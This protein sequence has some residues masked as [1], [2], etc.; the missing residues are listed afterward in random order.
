MSFSI[1]GL[2]T[3]VPPNC[4]SQEDA[5]E[6]S[7]ELICEDTR[8]QRLLRV[9]FRQSGVENRHTVIP[10]QTGYTCKRDEGQLGSGRGPT[11]ADT[12]GVIESLIE[13]YEYWD[14]QDLADDWRTQLP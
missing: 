6:M 8:Q 1:L 12:V 9:L 13:L 7:T 11:R 10:W 5:L 2:G 4:V 3:A 14:K